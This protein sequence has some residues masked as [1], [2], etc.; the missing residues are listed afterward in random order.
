MTLAKARPCADC[1][2][3]YPPYVMQFDHREPKT[4]LFVIGASLFSRSL[5]AV[6]AEIEKCDVVCANCHFQ[7]TWERTHRE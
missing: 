1:G 2:V 6:L 5:S 4:K 7:R 3:Q